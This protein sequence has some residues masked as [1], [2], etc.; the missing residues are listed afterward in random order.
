MRQ[1]RFDPDDIWLYWDVFLLIGLIF[2]LWS[3]IGSVAFFGFLFVAAWIAYRYF[4]SDSKNK[5][6]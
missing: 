2:G 6:S 4:G 5:K 3:M 1:V